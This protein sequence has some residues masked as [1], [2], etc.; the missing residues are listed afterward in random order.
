MK[1]KGRERK[2][3]GRGRKR[4]GRGRKGEWRGKGEENF[5]LPLLFLFLTTYRTMMMTRYVGHTREEN[6]QQARPSAPKMMQAKLST[7]LGCAW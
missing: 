3:E 1:E 6:N 5:N 2:R 4:E 7:W